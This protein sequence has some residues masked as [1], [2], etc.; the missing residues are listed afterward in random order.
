V[1]A[2]GEFAD[3][4]HATVARGVYLDH[5]RMLTEDDVGA[6]GTRPTTIAG[7]AFLRRSL[8]EQR[9][10]ADTGERGLAK[11]RPSGEEQL[12]GKFSRRDGALQRDSGVALTH[13]IGET[14]RTVPSGN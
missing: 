8:T 13:Y 3:L 9:G 14:V 7:G 5:V 2:G 12:L 1:R 4:V 10:G 11:A 6:V